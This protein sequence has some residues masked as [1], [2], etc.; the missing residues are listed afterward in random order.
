[1]E[2]PVGF[3]LPPSSIA[4]QADN[5]L[6]GPVAAVIGAIEAD[7]IRGRILPRMRLIEDHLMEDYAVKRNVIRAALQELQRLG[8]VVKPRHRGAELRRFDRAELGKLYDMR[9]VLHRAAVQAIAL[10][11]APARLAL[12][13]AAL[14]AHAEA[15]AGKDVVRI[16]RTNM[17]FHHALYGLCDNAYLAESIRLHDWIS[18]PVRAYGVADVDALR[19]AGAE[20]AEMVRCLDEQDRAT[21]AR[22][23]VCHMDHARQ[24]YA[25]RFFA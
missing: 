4:G 10:P 25:D 3:V 22:L 8:V 20:H 13:R 7:I 24:I 17:A 15:A 2:F 23:A 18:F 12:L 6:P 11:V 1:M 19:Q 14:T 16:H 5:V 21:L 9:A